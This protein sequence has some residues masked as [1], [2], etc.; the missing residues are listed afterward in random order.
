MPAW[1]PL[2]A[3]KPSKMCGAVEIAHA[4][5]QW[6]A[7]FAR[8]AVP[9]Q[10]DDAHASL[11]WR[12]DLQALSTDAAPLDGR[13]VAVALRVHDLRLMIL[14]DGAI[15]DGLS[16]HGVKDSDAGGWL[17][18]ALGG[19]GL[20][21]NA[22]SEAAPYELPAYADMTGRRH[23]AHSEIAGLSELARAFDAADSVL[24]A[25]VETED[26]ASPVR[27]W[28]HH[29]DIATLVT[30]DAERAVGAGL[31]IPDKLYDELY[32]Y[33]Y[34]WPRHERKGLPRLKSKGRYQ[35]KG[36]FGAVLPMSRLV[37]RK[38]QAGVLRA[39]FKES[40]GVFRGLLEAEARG[41]R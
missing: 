12:R 25:F 10:P 34:P 32:W 17:R 2:G 29:F 31:A 30:L 39:F 37:K 41:E 19:R 22:L 14:V 28:P 24:N 3:V 9:P 35:K 5:V 16:L 6:P 13:A 33:A 18:A 11:Y 20:A 1:T 36:F 26:G 38:D 4:A 40:A 8:G 27:L 23:D 21:L 15:A 7:R